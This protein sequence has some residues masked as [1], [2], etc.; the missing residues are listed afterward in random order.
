MKGTVVLQVRIFE[1]D[2]DY[3][4][5]NSFNL[6]KLIRRLVQNHVVQHRTITKQ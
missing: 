1:D 2:Y 5:R 4:S 6:S 3:L